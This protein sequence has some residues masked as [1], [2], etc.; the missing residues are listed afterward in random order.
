[1]K[2]L[3]LR[4][5]LPIAAVLIGTVAQSMAASPY[6]T[7][8]ATTVR[9]ITN[10]VAKGNATSL[11]QAAL[12]KQLFHENTILDARWN[13]SGQVQLSIHYNKDISIPDTQKLVSMGVKGIRVIPELSIV[14]AWVPS[15]KINAIAALDWVTWLSIP[16]YL[17]SSSYYPPN[18]ISRAS[19]IDSQAD[20]VMGAAA[21]RSATGDNG[22]GV[23]VGVINIGDAG[24]SQS[25]SAGDLPS[26]VYISTTYP[27]NGTD[28]EGTAMMELVHTLAPGANLAFCGPQTDADFLGCLDDLYTNAHANI[29]VDDIGYLGTAYFTNDSDVTAVQQWQTSHGSVRLVTAA[30]NLATSFWSGTWNPVAVQPTAINGVTYNTVMNFGT[31]QSPNYYIQISVAPM[32]SVVYIFEWDDSWIPTA[33]LNGNSPND[34]NDYDVILF[35]SNF[36]IIACNQGETSDN[37]GCSQSGA[38]SSATPGPEPA[39]YNSWQNTSNSVVNVYLS[40]AYRAGSPGTSLKVV[41]FSPNSCEV[42]LN[43]VTASDSII[44]HATLTYPA[45]ISVAAINATSAQNG[46]YATEFFSSQGPVLLPL[47]TNSPIQKPDFAGLDGI[48]ISGSGGFPPALCGSVQP[49]PIYYGTSAA[50]PQVAGLIALLESAGYTSDQV[51]GVLQQNAITVPPGSPNYTAGYGLADIANVKAAGSGNGG[52]GGSNGGSSSG[53]GGGFDLWMLSLTGLLLLVMRKRR[54]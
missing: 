47:L 12:T 43:P 22:S 8:L 24:L 53:G 44:G 48:T 14:Q 29:I 52:G 54:L 39:V 51:Y 6:D 17:T 46:Q 1:M 20:S 28:G 45:E 18:P 34:P 26:N 23:T 36:N 19:N 13:A 5:L 2:Y 32:D 16:H 30:G 38:Q 41:V 31:A 25:Q 49:P 33:Q 21:F 15:D 37:T 42:Q 27:G 3:S 7:K 50:A 11:M 9:S 10:A 4:L 35:D 40:F